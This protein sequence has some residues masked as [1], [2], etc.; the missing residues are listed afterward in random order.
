LAS[1][2][3]V[4]GN[5]TRSRPTRV[6]THDFADGSF[7]EHATAIPYGVYDAANDEGWVSVGDTADT[8][9]FAVESIRRWWNTLG[10]SR[11]P[12]A[13]TLTITADGVVRTG[14]GPRVEGRAG[15][16]RHGDRTHGHGV[17]LPVGYVEV[18]PDRASAVLVHLV[19]LARKAAHDICAIVELFGATTTKT[20]LTVNCAHDPN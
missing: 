3:T 15:K 17:A 8:A 18:E 13:S 16:V 4:A 9:E 19:Q 12:N 5:G 2:Q 11:F 10:Q 7:G 20:G 6:S 1:T 14:T